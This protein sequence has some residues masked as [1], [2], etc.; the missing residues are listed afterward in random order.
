MRIYYKFVLLTALTLSLVLQSSARPGTE[1]ETRKYSKLSVGKKFTLAKKLMSDGSYINAAQYLD[2]VCTKKPKNFKALYLA[3]KANQM[4]RDYV[5]AEDYYKKLLD[6]KPDKYP[7]AR[8]NYGMMLKMN[9][10]YDESKKAYKDFIDNYSGSDKDRMLAWAKREMEGCD[11]AKDIVK[12][13]NGKQKVEHLPTPVNN[14]LTEL[15]PKW[16]SK[17]KIMFGSFPHDTAINLTSFWKNKKDY[18]T[19]IYTS[20]ST[21]SNNWS[22][23]ELVPGGVNDPKFHCGNAV[24]SADGQTMYFTKCIEDDMLNMICK[25]YSSKKD[26]DKWGEAKECTAI[27]SAEKNVTTTEPAIGKDANGKELLYFVSNREGGQGGLDIWFSA[28]DNSGNLSA[29][30]NAGKVIN[31]V[32]DEMTPFYDAANSKLY[33]A[34]NGQKNIGGFD[35]FVVKGNIDGWDT[36]KNMGVPVNS[37][38]DDLYLAL[39]EEGEQG[40]MVSNRPGVISPRGS[41]ATDDIF[42]VYLGGKKIYVKGFYAQ[43]GDPKQTPLSGVDNSL[44]ADNNGTSEFINK[45]ITSGDNTFVY[46]IKPG[47]QY[48]ITGNKNGYYPGVDNFESPGKIKNESDTILQ[49]FLLTPIVKNQVK[50]ENVYFVFDKSGL[51]K[52]NPTSKI[53]S[54]VSFLETHANYGVEVNGHT[55]NKGT[56]EYNDKLSLRRAGEVAKYITD[57]KKLS[58]DRVLVKG[59]GE[60][61]PLVPNEFPDGRDN[62]QGRATNRR[63]QFVLITDDTKSVEVIYDTA[64]PQGA[65]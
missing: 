31:T 16:L 44:F 45:S 24:I 60:K 35:M 30:K 36:I 9:G 38:A 6:V 63:V 2:E 41:T 27:N 26:G 52:E 5:R 12:N 25:I 43:K 55:D 62:P 58:K 3:A 21:G 65:E 34:S 4:N 15:S 56:D 61:Q 32:G 42:Y 64:P 13:P 14:E 49:V 37:S 53:D 57:T 23:P 40:Y 22:D 11:I 19:K 10:K 20:N 50:I 33:F 1:Q 18:R 59:F 47:T 17:D 39:D 51:D 29:P 7:M 48:K 28:I 46:E 8:F 54:L